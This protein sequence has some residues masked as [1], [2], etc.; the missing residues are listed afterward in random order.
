MTKKKKEN[1]TYLTKLFGITPKKPLLWLCFALLQAAPCALP[2]P[3]WRA[4]ASAS[5]VGSCRLW[6]LSSRFQISQ[7]ESQRKRQ[8]G[9]DAPLLCSGGVPVPPLAA[10]YS[11]SVEALCFWSGGSRCLYV[12]RFAAFLCLCAVFSPLVV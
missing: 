6:S 9:R 4:R 2:P 10:A 5:R 1:N 11:L 3:I 12:A 8:Q 7:Q